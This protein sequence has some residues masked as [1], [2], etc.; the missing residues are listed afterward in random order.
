MDKNERLTMIVFDGDLDKAM[1]SF[2]IATGAAAMG[3]QVTMFFTFW[4]L[5]V[6]RKDEPIQAKKKFMEKM[7]ERMMPRGPK[8][9]QL[10]NMNMAGMGPKV[11]KKMM[12]DHNV[13]TL[14]EMIDMAE[15]LDIKMVACTMSMDVMGLKQ[16]ELRD[17]L[18]YAGVASYLAEADEANTNLFI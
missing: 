12:K 6:L 16:E 10:S 3:K 18:E 7:F 14:D 2:I 5:N 11:M 17:G 4:G 1:A 8:K 13:S 9:L 15:E